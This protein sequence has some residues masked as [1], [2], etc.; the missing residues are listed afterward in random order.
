MPGSK[1]F[2]DRGKLSPYYIP[3]VL[4]HRDEQI[5]RLLSIYGRIVEDAE[6]GAYLRIV[7]LVGSAGTGKTCTALRFGELIVE[8]A[9][10][11]GVNLQ[12]AYLNCKVDG[13]KR[14]VLYGSLAGKVVPT[15]ST[16]SLSPEAILRQLVEY[17]RREDRYLIA[18]LDEV[19]YFVQAN[20]KEHI[21]YD[22][23]RIPEMFPGEPSP[24]IGEIF[25]SRSLKW[26]ERLEEGEKSTLG[27]G[28][29]RFPRY[30]ADQVM[31]ILEERVEE[32]FQPGAVELDAL[33]LISDVTASPPVNGDM[34]FALDLLYY[35]GT[36]AENLG[37]ERVRPE[38]VRKVYGE[39]NP[40]LTTEDIMS[41]DDEG[42]L[43]LLALVRALKAEG[44]AYVGLRTIRDHYWMIC[45]EQGRRPVEEFEEK[46]QDL[47]Y[48][49]IVDMKSLTEFGISAAPV[50]DL[51]R[52]LDSLL[53]RLEEA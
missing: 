8:H 27:L 32:A 38:H 1:I 23:T 17:L 46:L 22:L 31:D 35:A 25:I 44:S 39:L 34:R 48:R 53:E 10:R 2:R 21:V 29:I 6:R 14:H 11:L 33:E 26:R 51:E 16:R 4:P 12:F 13:A 45:E 18:C 19:D 20:P 50:T 47:I 5:E 41:L 15:L 3:K 43:I 36:L 40:T 49:G 37:A 9:K 42:K 24:V 30:T 28:I 52:F 7:Q